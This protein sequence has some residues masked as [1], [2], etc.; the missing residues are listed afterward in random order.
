MKL[1]LVDV[2]NNTYQTTF[3]TCDLCLSTGTA[4]EDTYVFRALADDGYAEIV[5]VEAFF[6][7]WGDL[8]TVDV[9]NQILFAEWFNAQEFE[10][11]STDQLHYSW[12]DDIVDQY[13][14][15]QYSSLE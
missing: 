7:S 3:G 10:V 5:E 8:F 6:W 11:D 2:E 9:D 15:A 1:K 13:H 12:L 14:N 4:S